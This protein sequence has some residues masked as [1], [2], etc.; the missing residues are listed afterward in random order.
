MIRNQK[1]N[2]KTVNLKA[3]KGTRRRIYENDCRSVVGFDRKTE[4]T[5]LNMVDLA[6]AVEEETAAAADDPLCDGMDEL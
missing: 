1:Q 5:R 6:D 2:E 4:E 3:P